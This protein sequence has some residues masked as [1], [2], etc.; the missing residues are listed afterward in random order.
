MLPRP[1]RGVVPPLLTPLT[2]QGQLDTAGLERLIE[3]VIE[4]GAAGL[5]V[6]GSSGEAPSLSYDIRRQLITAACQQ[7]T[8]R[9]PVLVGISDS[10]PA[11]SIALAKFA[12]EAGAQAVVAAPPYYFPLSQQDL[13][14]YYTDLASQ[15]PLPLYLYNMPSMTKLFIED[16]TVAELMKH[17]NITGIKDSSGD[18]NYFHRIIQHAKSDPT[19]TV[20]VGPEELTVEAVLFGGHGG[21]NGGSNLHP[22][23][24]VAM[25]EAAA[26]GDMP[27]AHRL[28]QQ[29]MELAR[30]YRSS[31]SSATITANL[32]YALSQLGV[33]GESTSSLFPA[34][35]PSQRQAMDE[36]IARIDFNSPR[37]A[38]P[39]S[40]I[41]RP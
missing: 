20:L 33:C 9:V 16:A 35:Q 6:L 37:A 26:A 29:V 19:F 12:A 28:H 15:S 27:R 17:E 11:E 21:V 39:Q 30:V 23:L 25:V 7:A 40:E 24:Y 38:S 41:P 1:L 5:F 3:R 13:I 32:K 14:A 10:A 2:P 22:R 18:M 36:L 4:G 31:R 8:F 34:L